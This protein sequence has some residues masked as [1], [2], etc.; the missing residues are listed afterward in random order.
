M[1]KRAIGAFLLHL[2]SCPN[3][4]QCNVDETLNNVRNVSTYVRDSL[5]RV[6]EVLQRNG[7][8]LRDFIDIDREVNLIDSVQ[9]LNT[10]YKQDKYFER[11][12]LVVKPQR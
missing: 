7:I 10:K 12:F 11:A 6:E 5:Y 3:I 1:L 2:R 8:Y 4:R 9:G